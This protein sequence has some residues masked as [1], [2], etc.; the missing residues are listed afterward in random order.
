M[1]RTDQNGRNSAKE[2]QGVARPTQLSQV[3]QVIKARYETINVIF[4]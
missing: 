3:S 4:I 2:E 1:P